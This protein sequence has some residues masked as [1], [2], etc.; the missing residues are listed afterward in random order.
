[1]PEAKT[2]PGQRISH[3][4][5]RTTEANTAFPSRKLLGVE[6]DVAGNGKSG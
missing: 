2:P 4:A 3:N 5:P 6:L 1:M